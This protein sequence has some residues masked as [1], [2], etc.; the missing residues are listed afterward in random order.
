MLK[1]RNC[2]FDSYLYAHDVKNKLESRVYRGNFFVDKI[3]GDIQ[4]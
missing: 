1:S 3:L 2:S 4:L